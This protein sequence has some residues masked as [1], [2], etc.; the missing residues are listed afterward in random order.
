[1]TTDIATAPTAEKPTT[2]TAREVPSTREEARFLAPPVD[3]WETEDG[4]TV[5]ADLPGV[6]PDAVDVKVE[7]GV[8]SIRGTSSYANPTDATLAEFS[9]AGYYREFQL[10]DRVDPERI[11]AE[12][13]NGVL[14][15]RLP[16]AEKA[17][18]KKVEVRVG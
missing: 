11:S 12:L 2:T 1:M 10:S 6:A 17:R 15:V 13:R 16:K 8:L 7:D 14:T 9:L 4:L 3:I 5:V 18:P